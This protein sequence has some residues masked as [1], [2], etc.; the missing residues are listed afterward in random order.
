[1]LSTFMFAATVACGV[2]AVAHAHDEP[3]PVSPTPVAETTVPVVATE[4]E[5]SNGIGTGV[6]LGGAF[7]VLLISGAAVL[8]SRKK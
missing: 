5:G 2:P 1:M 7:S 3:F 8:L 4:S 6:V